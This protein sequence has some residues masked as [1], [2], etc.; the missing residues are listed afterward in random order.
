MENTLNLNVG[1][2]GHVDSGKTS[3]AKRIS[4]I[5]STASFDKNPQ[6]Q[7]RGIT[8]DLGFSS[9]KCPIPDHL[10]GQNDKLKHLQFTFVDCP[11]H[12]SLLRTVIGG[13]Q[14]TDM[15]I[16]VLD[17]CKGI[18]TQTAE[19][20]VLGEVTCSRMVVVLNKIDMIPEE[21]RVST[22]QK[23][24]KKMQLTL[25]DS[26]FKDSPI[27]SLAANPGGSDISA[28]IPVGIDSL[29][30][31]LKRHAVIPERSP[32][33]PFLF[34]VDHCF[35]IRGQGTVITGTVL[36][37]SVSVGDVIEIPS[38]KLEKKVKSMQMFHQNVTSAHQ[39]DRLGICVKQLDSN[40][41][42]RG[43]ICAPSYSST[44]HAA[45]I[46]LNVIKYFKSNLRSNSKFHISIGYETVIGRITIFRVCHSQGDNDLKDVTVKSQDNIRSSKSEV[47]NTQD[48]VGNSKDNVCNTQDNVGNSNDTFN[49]QRNVSNSQNLFK[50]SEASV[51]NSQHS[52]A[53]SQTF[54]DSENSISNPQEVVYDMD[55]EYLYIKEYCHV[56]DKNNPDMNRNETK[57]QHFVLIEFETPVLTTPNSLVIGSRLDMDMHKNNCR[58]AF[59][60]GLIWGFTS[61]NYPQTDL[62][63]LKV[64]SLKSKV[65]TVDRVV[66]R[67]TV[68]G[69]NIF[70][71]E[72]NLGQFVGLEVQFS[73]GEVGRIEGGFGLS[74]KVKIC[75]RGGLKEETVSRV[76]GKKKKSKVCDVS[77]VKEGMNLEPVRFT[78]CF[79]KFKYDSS[80]K[81]TQ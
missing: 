51:A 23:V 48:S 38:L 74:G 15:I 13:A 30:E 63:S 56:V 19:C 61:K 50:N 52:V 69:R 21:K 70:K 57:L 9:L 75:V 58:L 11:G 62:P 81:I 33:K 12:A 37:G 79:K 46:P 40:H 20:L 35:G 34:A 80:K 41:L 59:W 6:S 2:L 66:D 65:G 3:L 78:M 76:E 49:T 53:N 18:Q 42:E 16:L 1:I 26:V 32:L 64:F 27:V 4:Q 72:T 10:K 5:A 29:I 60:G 71:K 44:L 22:I 39:G 17:I 7:E 77:D 36:Q 28:Q 8:I 67:Y 14:I 25:R 54:G 24:S 47:C 31:V 68:I 55:K 73:T 43:I 45:I